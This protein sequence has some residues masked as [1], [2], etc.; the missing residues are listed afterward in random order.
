MIQSI[1]DWSNLF[2]YIC[3][4]LF[5]Q[6][7]IQSWHFLGVVIKHLLQVQEKY[8]VVFQF[9]LRIKNCVYEYMVFSLSCC[10]I[11]W[12]LVNGV[13]AQ[14]LKIILVY[15]LLWLIE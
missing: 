3:R 12:M 1:Y 7:C 6:Y 11:D 9:E 2:C 14:W 15:F 10:K 4:Y 5:T 8:M 13:D